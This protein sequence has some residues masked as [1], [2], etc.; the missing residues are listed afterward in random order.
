MNT[1]NEL[2]SSNEEPEKVEIKENVIERK[3]EE[4]KKRKVA[5]MDEEYQEISSIKSKT[6]VKILSFVA[7]FLGTIMGTIWSLFSLGIDK[8]K[9]TLIIGILVSTAIG[10][11]LGGVLSLKI[12]SDELETT[13]IDM[14]KSM[15]TKHMKT[16]IMYE[17]LS[18]EK[19]ELQQKH[20]KLIED[21]DKLRKEHEERILKEKVEA[22][23]KL[24]EKEINDRV[25]AE[26]NK[27][28]EEKLKELT[29]VEE[30]K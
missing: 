17:Q 21:T 19:E 26:I 4:N 23:V 13:E 14:Y 27:R 30:P 5:K 8:E 10:N 25:E 29:P 1:I 11:I 15:K 22:Q 3:V 2:L 16:D 28:V 20:I 24:R 9:L 12:T 6:G 18:K 7:P